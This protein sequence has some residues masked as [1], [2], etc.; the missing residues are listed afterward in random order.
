MVNNQSEASG[1]PPRY[2]KL[3][4]DWN[5]YEENNC[6]CPKGR[7]GMP[8]APFPNGQMEIGPD[9][10]FDLLCEW[11]AANFVVCAGTG[12]GSDK[13]NTDGIVDGHA[14]SV[15]SAKKQ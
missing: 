9:E 11:D 7:A 3:Q 6:Q 10:L 1:G 14:Y 13:N 15:I 4:P 12:A 2:A 5:S 8:L